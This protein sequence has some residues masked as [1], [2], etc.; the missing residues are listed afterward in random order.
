MFA[1]RIRED[2]LKVVLFWARRRVGARWSAERPNLAL[3]G[4]GEPG[5]DLVPLPE[6]FL[7]ADEGQD[8]TLGFLDVGRPVGVLI[9][10]SSSLAGLMASG[11]YSVDLARRVTLTMLL[12][13]LACI[14]L[15]TPVHGEGSSDTTA[16]SRTEFG[17][18]GAAR[19]NDRAALLMTFTA[20]DGV[21]VT[22]GEQ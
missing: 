20:S 7:E 5:H 19:S 17:T 15:P 16:T 4:V 12:G 11:R 1:A 9:R 13:S 2:D 14:A 6:A 3:F 21:F 22:E 18:A 8:V 10:K